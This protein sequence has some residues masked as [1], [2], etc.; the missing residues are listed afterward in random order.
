MPQGGDYRIVFSSD[1]PETGGFSRVREGYR[2]TS[3]EKDGVDFL[4][5]YLPSRMCMVLEW[6][7]NTPKEKASKGK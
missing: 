4:S 6:V 1:D 5:V 7:G 2:F 3:F